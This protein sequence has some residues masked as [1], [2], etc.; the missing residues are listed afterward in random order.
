MPNEI[1]VCILCLLEVKDV[2]SLRLAS[3]SF[4]NLLNLNAF[5]ISRSILPSSSLG[6]DPLYLQTLYPQPSPN[7]NLDYFVQILHRHAVVEKVVVTIADF[8]QVEI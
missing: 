2:L 7:Q 4:F 8:I 5:T 6:G 1:R 3:Q